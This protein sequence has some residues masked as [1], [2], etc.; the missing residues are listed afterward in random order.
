MQMKTMDSM[1]EMRGTTMNGLASKSRRR[2]LLV[3]LIVALFLLNAAAGYER[4]FDEGRRK[5]RSWESV[6]V[7][8]LKSDKAKE[9]RISSN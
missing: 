1:N 8:A 6:Y 3:E 5:V 9:K 4:I 7:P 2:S